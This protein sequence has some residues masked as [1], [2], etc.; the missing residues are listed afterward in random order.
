MAKFGFRSLL[1][2]LAFVYNHAKETFLSFN[3][4]SLN[5]EYILITMYLSGTEEPSPLLGTLLVKFLEFDS[6]YISQAGLRSFCKPC[7]IKF[8]LNFWV[9]IR[10]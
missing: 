1:I 4:A 10:I 5:F 2:I 7:T 9:P 6:K 3:Q 8:G